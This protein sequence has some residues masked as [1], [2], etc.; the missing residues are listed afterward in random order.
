MV[1]AAPGIA[2]VR[3]D[4]G[5]VEGHA[6]FTGPARVYLTKIDAE[7]GPD[8]DPVGNIVRSETQRDGLPNLEPDQIRRESAILWCAGS[9]IDGPM[10]RQK[11]TDSVLVSKDRDGNADH[12]RQ[13][14]E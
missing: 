12:E 7:A 11:R 8:R 9:D 6:D 3:V 4:A 10:A 5:F 1:D 2:V 13:K 14:N